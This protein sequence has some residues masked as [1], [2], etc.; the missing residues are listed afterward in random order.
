MTKTVFSLSLLLL[1][2]FSAACFP[3]EEAPALLSGAPSTPGR[4]AFFVAFYAGDYDAL[5]EIIELLTRE[6]L[7]GDDISTATLGFA[8]AWRLAESSRNS[9]GPARVIESADLAVR[10]FEESS[11]VF[12][13]DARLRGFLGSFKQASGSIHGHDDLKTEG[14]FD[15]QGAAQDWPEWG[16]FTQAYGLVTLEPSETRYN[17]GIELYWKNIDA[18]IDGSIDRNNFDYLPYV[19]DVQNDSDERDSRAC[20]NSEVVPFNT[21]GF[22][23]IFGDMLAKGNQLEDAEKMYQ[24]ALDIP[25]DEAWPYRELTENRLET[26]SDLPNAFAKDVERG[27]EVNPYKTTI[28]SGPMNCV[29]CHEGAA[30]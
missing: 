26:L 23:L 28:F 4:D 3:L 20:G 17:D 7:D 8:H 24:T 13:N 12:P 15:Q 29:A 19:E 2:A 11:E 30:L 14:W 25:S 1:L 22:F 10:F 6:Y 16:Y 21:Q 27:S 18:C 5:D 9:E